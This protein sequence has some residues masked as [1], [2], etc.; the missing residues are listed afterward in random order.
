MSITLKRIAKRS[1]Y[2][3]GKIYIDGK[4]FCDSIEDKDRN[5]TQTTPLEQIKKVK[6]ASQ[7]AIPTGT[8]D[9]TMNVISPRFSQKAFYKQNCNGGRVP[10]LL[11]VPGFDGVLI[12]IGNTAKD[13]AG[14]ILVGKN[15]QVGKVLNS[16]TTFL[17]LYK[18]LDAA[19]KKGEKITIT[20][21]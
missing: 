20:I 11:D 16:T 9:I 4:Y 17:N 5:I 3:I 18:V 6:V 13:S 1:T 12:H 10:R 19:N 8:Y 15:S 7:T 14:C 2:T 21:Q